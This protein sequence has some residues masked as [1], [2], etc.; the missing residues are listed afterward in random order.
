MK[1]WISF[2]SITTSLVVIFW[3]RIIATEPLV[4]RTI[5]QSSTA[6]PVEPGPRFASE[7]WRQNHGPSAGTRF[8]VADTASV[9]RSQAVTV[10]IIISAAGLCGVPPGLALRLAARESSMRQWDAQ[11]NVLR[12][13]SGAVGLFQIK[14]GSSPSKTLNLETEWGNSVAGLCHLSSLQ[15]T[16]HQR[17]LSYRLGQYRR[18][19]S[20]DAVKYAQQIAGN[21]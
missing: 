20:M 18:S 4:L 5:N 17:L 14:P 7:S 21:E 19:T 12:S 1:L 16:W 11:G 13:S 6:R 8:A 9:T 10:R 15:G 3:S 2:L